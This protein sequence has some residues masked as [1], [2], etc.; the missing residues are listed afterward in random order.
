MAKVRGYLRQVDP[1]Q[2][3]PSLLDPRWNVHSS[4]AFKATVAAG[5]PD[6]KIPEAHKIAAD[7]DIKRRGQALDIQA[8]GYELNALGGKLDQ[9]T[10]EMSNKAVELTGRV[11]KNAADSTASILHYMSTRLR[12]MQDSY[13]QTEVLEAIGKAKQESNQYLYDP[14]KGLKATKVL[15]QA[16]GAYKSSEE[17]YTGLVGKYTSGLRTVKQ[18]NKFIEIIASHIDSKQK[19]VSVHEAQ[20]LEKYKEVT[21]KNAIATAQQSMANDFS[22]DGM[23]DNLKTIELAV[24]NYMTGADERSTQLAIRD[25]YSGGI[26]QQV[27][28]LSQKDPEKALAWYNAN[29]HNITSQDQGK[30]YIQLLNSAEQAE[31]S[32]LAYQYYQ[33]TKDPVKARAQMSDYLEEQVIS[34]AMT[35][36]KREE[37]EKRASPLFNR[38]DK[39]EEARKE[40]V[41]AAIYATSLSHPNLMFN[42]NQ[43]IAAIQNGDLSEKD[44]RSF[45]DTNRVIKERLRNAALTELNLANTAEER[46]WKNKKKSVGKFER[47]LLELSRERG[48]SVDL[49]IET[50]HSHM[51]LAYRG[52]LSYEDILAA[53]R[54]D[55]YTPT[56]AANL[57][58][59]LTSRGS[60]SESQLTLV[61]ETRA[62][63]K[64]MIESTKRLGSKKDGDEMGYGPAFTIAAWDYFE[65]FSSRI[66]DE[67]SAQQVLYDALK[68]GA[69]KSAMYYK[70]RPNSGADKGVDATN[71]I[72]EER[73]KQG[74]NLSALSE[75]SF[76]FMSQTQSSQKTKNHLETGT[77]RLFA[78][79]SGNVVYVVA[80]VDKDGVPFDLERMSDRNVSNAVYNNV[81]NGEVL[82]KYT[83]AD[84]DIMTRDVS[85]YV[86]IEPTRKY[87]ITFLENYLLGE[88]IPEEVIQGTTKETKM[89]SDSE[90]LNKKTP[91]NR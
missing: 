4:D 48:G 91:V 58:K 23:L 77:A 67:N 50:Y 27:K 14:E 70:Y 33:E 75:D 16:S 89:L 54:S 40:K 29:I 57:S 1:K 5:L 39:V 2:L 56:M 24:R 3:E 71:K 49:A 69:D 86:G 6:D 83:K 72:I 60:H 62:Q 85:A 37:M 8:A 28:Q 81:I 73:K 22:E 13:D 66:T 78:Y 80:G 64:S 76:S 52:M 26:I 9:A 55:I 51:N 79:P 11:A 38:I 12:A 88:R 15:G 32:R 82:G 20:Q 17:Y 43:I 87:G 65:R 42:E 59:I 63:L 30:I 34:G 31:T 90:I 41:K 25:A 61:K 46:A 19:E 47:E 10:M 36:E 74:H 53:V 18:R 45:L 68:V 7:A 84:L 35:P 44:G 21:T